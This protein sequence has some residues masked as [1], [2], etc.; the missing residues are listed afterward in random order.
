MPEGRPAISADLRRQV[1][2]EV[3]YGCAIPACR[4]TELEI[5]HIVPWA[6][7]KVHEFHNLIAL[8][9]NHHRRQER[10]EIDRKAIRQIKENLSLSGSRYTELERRIIAEIARTRQNAIAL[11]WSMELMYRG[12]IED[13]V[14]ADAVDGTKDEIRGASIAQVFTDADT[15][16]E[17]RIPMGARLLMVTD[18][19]HEFARRWAAGEPMRDLL[20]TG[21]R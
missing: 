17:T 7:V 9:A 8:R 18:Q 13:G 20:D 14:L 19:G 5:A 3:G 4:E 15:G 6:E 2:I 16:E 10:G 11:D 1:L 21:E 12:L